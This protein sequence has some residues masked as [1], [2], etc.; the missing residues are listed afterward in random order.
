MA[1]LVVNELLAALWLIVI[2]RGHH[3]V[4]RAFEV[5]GWSLL[6]STILPAR[7][8]DLAWMY[9]IH[10]KMKIAPGRAIFIALYHRLLDFVVVSLLFLASIPLVGIDLLGA[11]IGLLAGLVLALLVGI[12]ATLESLLTLG[13]RLLLKIDRSFDR[14]LIRKL[15]GQLLHVRVWYRH[16]LP[17]AM[18]WGTF[19]IIVVR[20]LAIVACLVLIIHST[21]GSLDWT[22][23]AFLSNV[24]I[25]FSI[26]PLQTI[27]GFGFG[28]VG[29]AWVLT[30]FGFGLAKASAISLLIRIVINLANVGFGLLIIAVSAA[31]EAMGARRRAR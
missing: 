29:L 4:G 11:N 20:W 31:S 19:A 5:V 23:S 10:Q 22:D 25:Y 3:A 13:A 18:L 12:A 17:K 7:L 30:L 2:T 28:E 9:L 1:L 21:A 27:G 8:G 6:A 15:L 14:R 24:Y 16:G 26:I